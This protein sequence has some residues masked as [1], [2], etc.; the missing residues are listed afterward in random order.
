[1]PTYTYLN[2][3]TSELEDHVHKIAE[4]DTFL[5]AHPH[6]TRKITTNKASIVTGIN[7]RPDSGFRDVLKSIKKASG[8]GS[9]IE[10]F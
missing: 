5:A 7:Q 9:T 2:S 8:R 10:T 4:M 1:M 6:L 3:E